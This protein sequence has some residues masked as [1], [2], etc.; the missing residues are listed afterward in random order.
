MTLKTMSGQ[1]RMPVFRMT[2]IILTPV[3]P[4][5]I[6]VIFRVPF[7]SFKRGSFFKLVLTPKEVRGFLFPRI[8]IPIILPH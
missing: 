4:S 1:V 7:W 2:K 3:A 8:A 6:L 5:K